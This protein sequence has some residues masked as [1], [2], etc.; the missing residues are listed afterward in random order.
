MLERYYDPKDGN[1]LV[2]DTNLKDIKLNHLRRSI[3]YVA[4]EPV[5][6]LGTIRENMLFANKDAKEND[7]IS[8]LTK[9][10]AKEFVDQLE[11][12]LDTYVGSSAIQNLS[13][14]QKQ[15][16]AIARALIKHPEILILDE[17][18]SALDPESE[19]EVLNAI[20]NIKDVEE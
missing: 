12:G 19:N 2:D 14:G 4:Q 1:I 20:K 9:A 10:N 7:I 11:N 5:L 15:R 13:G 3:G 17:A 6:I 16:L 8:A 18:T